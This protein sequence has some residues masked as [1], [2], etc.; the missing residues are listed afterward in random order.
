MAVFDTSRTTYGATSSSSRFG[1]FFTN[2]FASLAAWNDARI[3]RKALNQLTDREL[4]D[5][6]LV[7]GDI[8]FVVEPHFIR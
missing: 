6:G 3:T 8:D 4:E 7:R 1:G 5:I 2:S